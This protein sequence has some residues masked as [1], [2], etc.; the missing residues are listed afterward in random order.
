MLPVFDNKMYIPADIM[1]S[2]KRVIKKQETN[3]KK[4]LDSHKFK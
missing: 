4:K 2:L 1:V 3:L